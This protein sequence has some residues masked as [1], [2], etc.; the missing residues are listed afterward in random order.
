[1]S[2]QHINYYSVNDYIV[3]E[4]YIIDEINYIAEK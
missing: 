1:M 4:P 3:S 2:N